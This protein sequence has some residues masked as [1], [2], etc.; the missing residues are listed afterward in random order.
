[1]SW[2]SLITSDRFSNQYVSSRAVTILHKTY[3]NTFRHMCPPQYLVKGLQFREQGGHGLIELY[4]DCGYGSPVVFTNNGRGD[5]NRKKTCNDLDHYG[6][7][8][9][10]GREQSRRGII[11]TNM[12]CTGSS[13]WTTSNGNMNGE[14]NAVQ[15]CPDKWV[16]TGF[17]VREQSGYGIINFRYRCTE[18]S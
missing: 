18:M 17:E 3:F 13:D 10:Q 16:I 7:R 4:M 12:L 8:A 9:V 6:F 14:W 1:M 5:P 15:Y 11:N 2:S